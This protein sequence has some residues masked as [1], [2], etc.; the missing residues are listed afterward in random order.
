MTAINL[1][2]DDLAIYLHLANA[3]ERRCRPLVR[4]KLLV[5]ASVAAARRRLDEIA[6]YCRRKIL[7]HNPA[8]LVGRWPSLDEALEDSEFLVYLRRLNQLYPLEKAEHML[9][10][11]GIE[12]ARERNLYLDDQEYAAALLG[13]SADSLADAAAGEVACASPLGVG[14]FRSPRRLRT[15]LADRLKALVR[16]LR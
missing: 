9:G 7:A 6:Q 1:P 14:R 13:A 16:F 4:D 8:H 2:I 5:L 10:M 3:S 11:L 12:L 15:T